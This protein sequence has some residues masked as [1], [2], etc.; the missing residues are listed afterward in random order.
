[1]SELETKLRERTDVESLINLKIK[2]LEEGRELVEKIS[3]SMSELLQE[4]IAT[5]GL[6]NIDSKCY[7]DVRYDLKTARHNIQYQLL[8]LAKLN[9]SK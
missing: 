6:S 5:P 9:R 3:K 2:T 8:R 7:S 4:A 1:M